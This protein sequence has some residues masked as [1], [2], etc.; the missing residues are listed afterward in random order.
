[1]DD[2]EECV[3]D[4]LPTWKTTLKWRRELL[5]WKGKDPGAESW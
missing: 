2:F 5:F 3:C 4:Y 1:M